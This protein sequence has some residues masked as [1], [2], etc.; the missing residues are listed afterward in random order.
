MQQKEELTSFW[1]SLIK[2]GD[3]QISFLLLHILLCDLGGL[4]KSEMP[5]KENNYFCAMIRN[6][7]YKD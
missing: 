6:M 4:V 1:E 7:S 2:V 3:F 5:L